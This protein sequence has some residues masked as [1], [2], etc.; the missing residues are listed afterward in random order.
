MLFKY[1]DRP[2]IIIYW[3]LVFSF[4]ISFHEMSHALVAYL[5]GDSTAKD[6]GRLTLDP[7]K[8][9]DPIGTLMIM[10]GIVGW[11][12]PVPVN[13]SN[14]RNKKWGSVLVSLAGPVS[15]LMLAFVFMIP[16]VYFGAKYNINTKGI[17]YRIVPT[18]EIEHIIMNIC[19]FGVRMNVA[20]AVFNLLPIPPLDGSKIFSSF[21][22]AKYYF[23]F[24][25]YQQIIYVIVLLTLFSG[26]FSI[27]LTPAI[28]YVVSAYIFMIKPIVGI[29]F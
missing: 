19:A 24:M 29:F 18:M 3:F 12:K 22:P 26:V 21:L 7:L 23:K 25:K 8:H 15:N 4:S 10:I 9:L 28:E 13:I 27:I 17:V 14:F 2:E 6:K 20:L 16:L 1:W 11:A 5:F